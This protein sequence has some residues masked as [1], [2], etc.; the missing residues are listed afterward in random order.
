MW[1]FTMRVP[2]SVPNQYICKVN[3]RKSFEQDIPL[4]IDVSEAPS[5]LM[6]PHSSRQMSH[7]NYQGQKGYIFRT[8]IGS[9]SELDHSQGP[10]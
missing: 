10:H 8:A 2:T 6:N 3:P 1:L 5:P 9:S 7:H 4:S